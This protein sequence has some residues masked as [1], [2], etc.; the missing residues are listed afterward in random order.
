MSNKVFFFYMY[1]LTMCDIIHKLAIDHAEKYMVYLLYTMC[2]S[3]CTTCISNAE[4]EVEVRT[5]AIQI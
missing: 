2:S 3:F 5:W 4:E 1:I